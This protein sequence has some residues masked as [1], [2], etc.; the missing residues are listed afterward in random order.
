MLALANKLTNSTQP[1]YRFVNKY[2]IDFDGVDDVIVTDGADTVAQKTTYAFWSKSSITG[3]NKGVFGHGG[4]D[5]GAF[6]FNWSYDRPFLYLGSNYYVFFNA[7]NKQGDGKWHQWVVYSD[8]NDITKCKLYCDGILIGVDNIETSGSAAAYTESLSIGANKKTGGNHFE[9]QIDEFAVYDR[10]LKQDEITRMYNTYYTPNRIANGNFA[11]IGNEEVSNGDFSEVGAEL[12]TNG[13][14]L[15]ASNWSTPT[16]W[17]I[18]GGKLK[19]TNLNAVSATQGGYSTFVGK[20]FLIVYTVSDYVQG[21]VRI[22]LGGNQATPDRTAN[23]TYTE[24]KTIDSGNNTLYIQ[25]VDGFTGSVDIISVKNNSVDW[26]VGEGWSVQGDNKAVRVAFSS[27]DLV[28]A[29]AFPSGFATKQFKISFDV[30]RSAGAVRLRAGTLNTPYVSATDTYTYYVTPTSNDQLKFQADNDFVG[31]VTNI[32]VKEVAQHWTLGAGT[33][34]ENGVANITA[35]SSGSSPLGQSGSLTVGKTFKV[36]FTISNYSSGSIAFSNLSPTTYRN[37]NGTHTL[38]GVGAGGDFLFFSSGFVGSID[39]VVVQELKSDAT[40]LMLNAGAYQ[41]ANPLIT[42]TKSMDFDGVDDYME[43]QNSSDLQLAGQEASF[44]FWT[45]LDSL[46]GGDQ[47][48]IAKAVSTG[49]DTSGYQ[50]RTDNDDLIFQFFS[51]SWRTTTSTSFFTD[52]NWVNVTITIDSSYLVKMYKNGVEEFSGNIGYAIPANTGELLFGA[53]T[54]SSPTNFLNGEMTEVGA[55]N[56]A[57]T[58]LEVASLYNQGMPTNLLV[59]RNDYQSGN[60]TVFNTKQVDFD[61]TDDYLQLGNF[62]NLG[63]SDCSFSFWVNLDSATNV[64]FAGKFQDNSNRVIFFTNGANQISTQGRIGG[65]YAW[66]FTGTGTNVLLTPYLNKWTH[67]AFCIDRSANLLIFINGELKSTTSISSTASTNVDNTG[68]WFF[69]QASGSFLNGQISQSGMWNKALTA[70]EVSSLYNHGLPIDLKTNQAAYT[71]SSNLVGY[72]R[73]GS[74]T[75]DTYPL[76]ADQTDATLGSEIVE[77]GDFPTG[78]TAW[79]KGAGWTISG[80]TANADTSGSSP[81]LQSVTLTVGKVYKIELTIS[82]LVAGQIQMQFGGYVLGQASVEGVKYFYYLSTVSNTSLYVYALGATELSVD[83]VSVKEVGGNPAIMTNMA[84]TDIE[85]G[86]PYANEV[87]NS[88]FET[89]VNSGQWA[90]FSSPTTAERSTTRAYAGKY[91]YHIVGDSSSDGTQASAGQFH[92]AVNDVVRVTAYV[93]PITADS[94]KIKT[95]VNDSS[96]GIGAEYNVTLNEWNKIEYDVT[97]TTASNNYISFLI[98]G[99]AGE[100]YLDNVTAVKLNTGLQGYWKMGDGINDEFPVIYDQT[101]PTNGAELVTNG[102]FSSGTNNYTVGTTVT[103]FTVTNG[104]A[105]IQGTADNFNTRIS[106][107]ITVVSGRT[108]KITGQVKSND[109]KDYRV[110][111]YNGDYTDIKNN[112]NSDY[113]TFTHYHTA[114]LTILIFYYSSFYT[115]GSADFSI[116][117]ISVKEVQGNPATMTNM[118]EGNIT[119]QYPLTKIRNYYR[120]GDGILDGFPIIQ[121]Q[122]SPNLAHI[123]TTNLAEYSENFISGTFW[124]FQGVNK[125][126]NSTISPDGIQNADKF[127]PSA[128]GSFKGLTKSFGSSLNASAYSLSAFVKKGGKDFFFFYNIG[129]PQGV[130]G[131]WFNLSTGVI[132]TKGGAYKNV[133]IEN[134]GNDWF[135]CSATLNYGGTDDYVYFL[136]S[137]SDN[138]TTATVNGTDGIY[139]WGVQIEEQSQATAYLKSDGIASVRKSTTTNLV[140][141]SEDYNQNVWQKINGVGLANNVAI[142]PNNTQTASKLTSTSS[143][144]YQYILNVST[145]SSSTRYTMS[146]FVKKE[147]TQTYFGGIGIDF[148]GGTRQTS[149]G[150]FDAVNGTIS[151]TGYSTNVTSN[152]ISYNEDWWRIQLN[153]SSNSGNNVASIECYATLSINGTATSPGLGSARTIWGFQLEEQTQ[154]ETYAPT[155]GLPVTIDL[156]TENNYGTMTN[157]VAGDIVLDTPNNPA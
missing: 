60:P 11:Q 89:A 114:S 52:L 116:D 64:T 128:S 68:N 87:E 92:W 112:N 50:I 149:Y 1:I 131:C 42:S 86:S 31:S 80:G 132:G 96:R 33:T 106:Q 34:I 118:V 148:Q 63:T 51:T 9:G 119:N 46:S 108:Y 139:L 43:V 37:S 120:M 133:K 61:G 82:N 67:I 94:D 104:V 140:N 59:N 40:N 36:S 15:S 38:I 137:D 145:I 129:S 98:S 84:S 57:L 74:G 10:E 28:Q 122:T 19:G 157:M 39:N 76:I 155:T 26:S 12:V 75:L 45:R 20:S 8:P 77:D 18:S 99:S 115:N 135:R 13:N 81:L 121:D 147:T 4:S 70:N 21:G 124:Q 56:R 109:N 2:S 100:F 3:A 90:N 66:N 27:T 126:D 29:G 6:H 113:E 102:D 79:N 85:N 35:A 117:N 103:S 101:N 125:I 105:T 83:N 88:T 95:G 130:N 7:L 71:S 127:Y 152:V 107:N 41:S 93:Y 154:A 150:I 49:S 138:N 78:T 16:G 134:V 32:T 123:P 146:V 72:W 91:S 73:M 23:G 54:P 44:T 65:N 97:I 153:A 25:G 142:A 22:F 136:T 111:I 17:A 53:R 69:G 24:Y 143:S 110:R 144:S 30:V 141:Y 58:P 156:F 48:F 5:V 151:I 55:Y 47:K 14:F 62:N